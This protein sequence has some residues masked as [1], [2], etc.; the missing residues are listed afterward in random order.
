MIRRESSSVYST[1]VHDQETENVTIEPL[2][3]CDDRKAKVNMADVVACC[4]R[5][6]WG[7]ASLTGVSL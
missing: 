4:D 1:L 6:S 3:P 5:L 7:C 2:F